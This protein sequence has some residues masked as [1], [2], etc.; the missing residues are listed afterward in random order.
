MPR[1][2]QPRPRSHP[3][4]TR[5]RVRSCSDTRMAE[6]KPSQGDNIAIAVFSIFGRQRQE[7]PY[8]STTGPHVEA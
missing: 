3:R 4:S 2:M 1:S 7:A 6:F 8:S 5:S